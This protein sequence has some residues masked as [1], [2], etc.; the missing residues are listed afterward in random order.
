MGD[1]ERQL[2]AVVAVAALVGDGQK[3]GGD[4]LG[5]RLARGL[6]GDVRDIGELAAGQRP[7]VHQG[8]KDGGARC[9]A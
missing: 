6:A 1:S 2:N 8:R 3:P 4:Q 7:A 9:M 5:E